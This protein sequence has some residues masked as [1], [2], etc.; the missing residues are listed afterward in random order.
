MAACQASTASGG[1]LGDMPARRPVALA[2]AVRDLYEMP[3]SQ[4][5]VMG[6]AGRRAFLENYTR[7]VLVDH[8]EALFAQVAQ[9]K[10]DKIPAS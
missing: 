8:Y 6:E 7:R 9:K 3:Q 4:R 5:E 2:Q 10:E 1:S